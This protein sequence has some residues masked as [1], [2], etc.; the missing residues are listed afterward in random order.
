MDQPA[1]HGG[2]RGVVLAAAATV[3]LVLLAGIMLTLGLRSSGPPQPPAADAA[4]ASPAPTATVATTPPPARPSPSA[5]SV[6]PPPDPAA[7]STRARP[8]D[9]GPI[10]PGSPP[11]RLDIP[12]IGVHTSTFV[13]LGR[14]RD[15]S[16]EVPQNF[17][18]AGFY[19][20]GPTPGQFGPAVIA[21]H[22]DSHQGPAVFY[23]LGALKAGATVSVGRRDGTTARFVVDKVAA[24]PKAQF[25]TTEVYGNTT[26]RAEL[27][28][29]TCGGSFDDRSGHYVDNVVAFAHLVSAT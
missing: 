28:L 25:P 13:D 10:L 18:A 26:S 16:I 1:Q 12:S 6:A 9:L 5:R 8:V 15:G 14:G 22:V 7:P 4:P 27:R 20:L 3:V 29:I 11:V 17:A 21:G 23:R 2:R 24:Y 19:T